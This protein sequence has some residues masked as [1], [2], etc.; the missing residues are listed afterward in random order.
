M[1]NQ[2]GYS[3]M[4]M[5]VAIAIFGILI[6]VVVSLE[7]QLIQ[8]DRAF[9]IRF[10]VHPEDMAVISRVRKDVLDAHS[11]PA[12]AGDYEQSP[13]TLILSHVNE[14][15]VLEEI[16]YDFTKSGQVRRLRFQQNKLMEEWMGR[17]LP[18]F[19][20]SSFEMPNEAVAV[21]LQGFDAKGQLVVD[22]ILL[23]RRN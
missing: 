21:R 18:K 8:F 3:L 23:P 7:R 22:Q 1:K 11:Y 17:G 6:L 5:V 2:R 15:D 19:G 9:K 13:E 12:K 14:D 4:E 20:V 10:M 16:V